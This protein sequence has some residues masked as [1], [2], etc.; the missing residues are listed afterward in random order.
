VT[1]DAAKE[2]ENRKVKPAAKQKKAKTITALVTSRYET[3]E[4]DAANVAR[5]KPQPRD[6]QLNTELGDEG[7][8]KKKTSKKTTAKSKEPEY[9]ILSPDAV[10]KTLNNQDILFGTCSQLETDDH[11]TFLRETQKAIAASENDTEFNKLLGQASTSASSKGIVSR[12]TGS[13]SLWSAATRNSDGF[14][15][16]PEILDMTNSPEIR[17]LRRPAAIE[18]VGSSQKVSTEPPSKSSERITPQELAT[19]KKTSDNHSKTRLE[20]PSSRK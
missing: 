9:I 11:P 20:R 12:F 7:A 1:A 10:T 5:Q 8:K 3:V 17:S 2:S 16:Q 4:A 18:N 15:V 13:K 14:V 19:Q 6:E